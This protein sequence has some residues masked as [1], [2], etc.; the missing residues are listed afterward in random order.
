MSRS[1]RRRGRRKSRRRGIEDK[2][3]E[4][5]ELEVGLDEARAGSSKE[6]RI[7]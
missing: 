2:E 5:E 1:T 7:E 3:E 4:K 6:R